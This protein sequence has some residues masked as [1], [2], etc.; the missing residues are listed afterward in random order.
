M[1]NKHEKYERLIAID[2]RVVHGGLEFSEPTLVNAQ[3]MVP[4]GSVIAI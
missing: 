1:Q 3:V 2:R 4:R